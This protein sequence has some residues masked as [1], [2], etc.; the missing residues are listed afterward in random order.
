MF[1]FLSPDIATLLIIMSSNS[2]R[3]GIIASAPIFSIAPGMT[4]GP[5]DLFLPI[6]A[7]RFLIKLILMVKVLSECVEI[8]SWMSRSQLKTE[9]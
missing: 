4:S 5:T 1:F 3:Y 6:I 8:I 2:A 7:N 9:A